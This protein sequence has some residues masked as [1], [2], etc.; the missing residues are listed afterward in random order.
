MERAQLE[1]LIRA[2]SAIADDYE[3]VVIGSQSILGSIPFP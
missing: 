3:L 1:R 2:A